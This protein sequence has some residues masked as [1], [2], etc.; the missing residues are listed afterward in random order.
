LEK[1]T[2]VV[3]GPN[4]NVTLSGINILSY[5]ALPL[6]SDDAV[7]GYSAEPTATEDIQ[8]IKG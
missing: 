8:A 6:G 7:I 3:I 1:I 4:V 2:E 5:V